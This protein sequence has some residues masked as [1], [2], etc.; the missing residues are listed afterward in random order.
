M[1]IEM[2]GWDPL[3]SRLSYKSREVILKN[4]SSIQRSL[5]WSTF[6]GCKCKHWNLSI[7]QNYLLRHVRLHLMPCPLL[8]YY[9]ME[10]YFSTSAGIEPNV[11]FVVSKSTRQSELNWVK[12]MKHSENWQTEMIVAST[13]NVICSFQSL[14]S[15]K[16]TS[17]IDGLILIILLL[18]W[19]KC[20]SST[21]L[22]LILHR[23]Y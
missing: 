1:I 23:L 5:E 18:I 11:I 20:I 9:S 7:N 12:R 4:L 19:V 14:S 2:V 8:L 22:M 17:K 21:S 6:W 13:I 3:A 16:A 10:I 15:P